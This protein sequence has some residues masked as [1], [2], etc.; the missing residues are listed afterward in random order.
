MDGLS[1][2]QAAC[3]NNHI[4]EVKKPIKC[5]NIN[6]NRSNDIGLFP[7][8]AASCYGYTDVVKELLNCENIDIAHT[9]N[10]GCTAFYGACKE[11][12]V[13]IMVDLIRYSADVNT[14][15]KNGLYRGHVIINT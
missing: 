10:E 7:L 5:D 8:Q 2:L 12:N 9:D 15:D 11:G 4:E 14:S 13:E 6:N 3:E 1:P